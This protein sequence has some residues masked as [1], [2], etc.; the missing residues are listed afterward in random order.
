MLAFSVRLKSSKNF[1]GNRMGIPLWFFPWLTRLSF[2]K[3]DEN[4]L[5][6]LICVLW[7]LNSSPILLLRPYGKK[8]QISVISFFAIK[9]L[10]LW[11]AYHTVISPIIFYF[12]SLYIFTFFGLCHVKSAQSWDLPIICLFS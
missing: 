11:C 2:F 7:V 9:V 4:L 6:I 3:K 5:T 8:L 12:C 10:L 1:C